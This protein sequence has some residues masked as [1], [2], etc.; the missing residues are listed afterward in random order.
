MVYKVADQSQIAFFFESVT[1][2]NATGAAVWVGQVLSNEIDEDMG[3][4]MSRY[5]G[6]SSRNVGQFINGPQNFVG[7]ISYRPQ[8]WTM[9]KFALGSLVDGGSPTPFQHIYSET[10]NGANVVDI[11]GQSLPSFQIEDVQRTVTGSNFMRTARGAI[12]DSF[13]ARASEGEPVTIDIN[14]VANNVVFA[15]G[16]ASALTAATTRPFMWSDVRVH[17]PSGTIYNQVK[18]LNIEINNNL[19]VPNYLD[20]SRTIGLPIPTNRD[21]T[22]SLTLNSDDVRTKTLYDNYFLGGSTF[23]M[24]VAFVASLGSREAAFTFSGCKLIDM[25]APTNAEG[26]NEQTITVRPLSCLV[27]EN[28]LTQYHNAGSYAGF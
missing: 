14:Y 12:V 11:A 5:A 17:I 18:D 10:N 22:V 15:S 20:G 25:A 3:V 8:D 1:W 9:L 19:D 6:T 27:L 2:T 21:Y 23:N 7:T 24:L 26:V 16:A 28:S 13:S 4:I